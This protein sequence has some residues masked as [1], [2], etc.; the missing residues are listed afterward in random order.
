MVPIR[1]RASACAASAQYRTAMQA[2]TRLT[3][4]RNPF[5]LSIKPPLGKP[6][7]HELAHSGHRVVGHSGP[8]LRSETRSECYRPDSWLRHGGDISRCS[9][10][11]RRVILDVESS[12]EEICH[13]R[14]Q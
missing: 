2:P 3:K 11:G 9:H 8:N 6:H 12:I 14:A 5:A 4:V 7:H 13:V 1:F 10:F